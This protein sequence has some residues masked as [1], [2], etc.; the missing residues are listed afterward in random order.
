MCVER[1][2]EVESAPPV[3]GPC[4]LAAA[5]SLPTPFLTYLELGDADAD[6]LPALARMT[7]S[8]LLAHARAFAAT[9][10]P[11]AKHPLRSPD[12]SA[13]ALER[14]RL[15]LFAA[16]VPLL[17]RTPG[18]TPAIVEVDVVALLKR[19]GLPHTKLEGAGQP[20]IARRS[21]ILDGLR[22]A[23]LDVTVDVLPRDFAVASWPALRA[24]LAAVAV[25]RT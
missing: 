20:A 2:E 12:E 4:G 14:H 19:A 7:P 5:C 22:E 6:P 23:A 18:P 9:R 24:V 25:A 13:S 15:V 10:A 8:R 17:L 11:G 1:L 21:H 16:S 3:T